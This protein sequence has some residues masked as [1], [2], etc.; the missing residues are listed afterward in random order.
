MSERHFGNHGMILIEIMVR[1][2]IIYYLMYVSIIYTKSSKVCV[3]MGN[4]SITFS[5]VACVIALAK[6]PVN[7][8]IIL[9]CV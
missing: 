1:D 7:N 9:P 5:N 4:L 3:L 2:S 6:N 8:C